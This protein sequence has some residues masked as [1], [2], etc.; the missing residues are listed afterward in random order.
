M[1]NTDNPILLANCLSVDEMSM[2]FYR[3]LWYDP[4]ERT[5]RFLLVDVRT[6]NGMLEFQ[7]LNWALLNDNRLLWAKPGGSYAYSN[8]KIASILPK[9]HLLPYP[10]LNEFYDLL[11]NHYDWT[12]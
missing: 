11:K 8:S 4:S 1:T 5:Y 3:Q 12:N 2:P 10:N 9:I 6:N 7:L